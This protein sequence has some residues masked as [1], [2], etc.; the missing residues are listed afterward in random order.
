MNK[1]FNEHTINPRNLTQYTAFRGVTD[2]TQIGQFDQYETGYQFLEVISVPKF[3]TA[4]A[5][6]DPDFAQINK[7]FVHMLEFEFRGLEGLNDITTDQMTITDGIN[8]QRMINRVSWDTAITV[9]MPYFE[10]RGSLITKYSEYYI[11]GIKDPKTQAKTY[12]GAIHDNLLEPSFE[13]EVFTLLYYVTD[14]TMLRLE[15]AVLLCNCQLT[16]AELSMYN[17]SRDA[18]NNRE[19]QIEFNCFPVIGYEVDKAA[20]HLLKDITGFEY[21]AAL[22][23]FKGSEN[24][25]LDSS[26]YRYGIMT[27]D[28]PSA[29]PRLVDAINGKTDKNPYSTGGYNGSGGYDPDRT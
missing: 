4:L 17:G 12:H 10:K 18:I 13:N 16:K 21:N 2:F 15:R 23:Q 11:T 7:S 9:S 3:L 20:N 28:N 5:D 6:K 14:N 8:E 24:T 25:I 29:D 22:K 26:S 1:L 19:M 27:K